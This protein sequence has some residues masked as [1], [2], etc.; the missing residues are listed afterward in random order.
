MR[1]KARMMNMTLGAF[2]E[3]ET[4][5]IDKLFPAIKSA[6]AVELAACG[7]VNKFGGEEVETSSVELEGLGEI[8]HA[9]TEM[10]E[11]VDGSWCLLEALECVG[12]PCLFFR[13]GDCEQSCQYLGHGRKPL[14]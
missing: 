13:L 3:E 8:G 12:W 6:K 14:T 1:L 11:F 10:P 4:M 2:E 7:I 9:D 5:V